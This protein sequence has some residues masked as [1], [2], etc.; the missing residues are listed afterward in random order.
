ME[1]ALVEF[2]GVLL[3]LLV[4]DLLK[5][6]SKHLVGDNGPLSNVSFFLAHGCSR[7][8]AG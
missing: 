8:A 2:V 4:F 1:A 3:R 6:S 7:L 5:D